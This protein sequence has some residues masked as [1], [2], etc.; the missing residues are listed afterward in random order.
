LER[1]Q[2]SGSPSTHATS[3][4]SLI[5]RNT[6]TTGSQELGLTR[7]SESPRQLD[8]QELRKTQHLRIPGS[9]NHR[10][11]GCQGVLTQPGSQERQASVRDNKGR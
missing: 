9:Q 4:E 5:P 6:D 10:I 7:I 2:A 8:Y 3:R 1:G 11:T